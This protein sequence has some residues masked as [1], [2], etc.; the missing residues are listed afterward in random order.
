MR[1]FA[2]A[3][4]AA[5]LLAMPA[6]ASDDDNKSETGK[7]CGNA[8]QSEWMSE[9]AI[10]A[11]G[12][13]LGLDVRKVKVEDGCYEIYGIDANKNRVEAYLN[14]VTGELVRQKMDD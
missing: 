2:P 1:Y 5:A 7:T 14:P 3:F 13:E 8:P 4:I 6:L 12:A 9:D 11:K 10:R